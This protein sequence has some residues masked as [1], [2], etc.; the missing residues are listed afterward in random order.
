MLTLFEGE[1]KDVRVKV[2]RK[3]GG[4]AFTATS[5]ERRILNAARTLVAAF[6]W[7]A[8]TWDG[9][10]AEVYTLFDSTATGLTTPATYYVQF[11][12]VIGTERY[13]AEQAVRVQEW[14]P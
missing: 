11:R 14:G 6:D 8:A 9:S 10:N 4:G 13:E 1:K 3:D 7:T 5:V 12:F 2:V